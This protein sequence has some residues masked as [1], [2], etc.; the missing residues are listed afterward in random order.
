MNGY[1]P[2]LMRSPRPPP[3]PPPLLQGYG[4][5]WHYI[6][7]QS[8]ME[9]TIESFWRMVMENGSSVVIDLCSGEDM[10]GLSVTQ[11]DGHVG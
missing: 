1:A 6:A 7:T 3:P 11:L 4:G 10:V 8:P 5:E 2:V 9:S